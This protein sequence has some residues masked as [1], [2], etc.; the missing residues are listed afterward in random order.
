MAGLLNMLDGDEGLIGALAL[1]SAGSA[2]PVRTSFADGLLGSIQAM[3]QAKNAREDR[4]M[5]KQQF[6]LQQQQTQLA[7]QQLQQQIAES[8]RQ[9]QRQRAM[10]DLPGQFMKP[11]QMP[12][13]MDNRD[14]GQPGEQQIPAQQFDMGGYANALFKYD[15]RT[16]IALQQSLRK[17]TTPIKV[18]AGEALLDPTT[19][20]PIFTNPKDD[21]PSDL[22]RLLTEMNALPPSDP[23]RAIYQQQITKMVT[24]AP[25]TQVV[26]MG[27]PVPVT[28]PDGTQALVQPSNRPGAPPQ[29]M[30][31]DG[32][33]PLRPKKDDKPPTDAQAKAATFLGQMRAATTTLGQVG[34]DQSNWREQAN[35]AIAGT[36]ANVLANEKGQQVRQAQ[37]QWA[38]AFLRFKT[39]AAST[40]QEVRRNVRTF[41]PQ[42]GDTP[43]VIA[44]KQR[45]REQ[46]EADIAIAAG[47]GAQQAQV[48]PSIANRQPASAGGA[49][50]DPDKERRYQEWKRQQGQ[51]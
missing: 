17:D 37:E 7:L 1:M 39:G 5:K 51:R 29:I 30:R 49:F 14:V 36:P 3:Q 42:M 22:A 9:A 10:E 38:E 44:Q 6:G 23:R 34:P 48:V 20:K 19:H 46:A 31:L 50:S 40:E 26:S 27:S 18:G 43:A 21:K 2:K 12:P 33:E 11:G 32:G 41:F 16:A 25:G 8:Q 45:M 4:D 24:H 47:P 28:L 35:V 15:P 13:S